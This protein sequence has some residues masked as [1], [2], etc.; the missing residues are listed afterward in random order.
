MDAR[1]DE[2]VADRHRLDRAGHHW[3]PVRAGCE[4]Y[5]T[6]TLRLLDP[7]GDGDGWIATGAIAGLAPRGWIRAG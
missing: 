3:R 1:L 5:S 6:A 4:W 7:I 2:N